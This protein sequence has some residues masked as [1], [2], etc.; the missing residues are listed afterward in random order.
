MALLKTS[1]LPIKEKKGGVSTGRT[2]LQWFYLKKLA[3]SKIENF[4]RYNGF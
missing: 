3:V 2:I 4:H 1:K